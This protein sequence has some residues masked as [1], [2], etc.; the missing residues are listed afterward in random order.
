[1]A[2]RPRVS[3]CIPVYNRPDY[4][5]E[6]VD[7]VLAQTFGD[8]ELIIVDNCSTDDTPAVIERLAAGDNRISFYKNDRNLG[9]C[10]SLN[11]LMLLA[12]GEYI[13][14]LFSDDLLEPR[15]LEVFVEV[16]DS[17]PSVSLVTSFTRCVGAS[18]ETRGE[19]CFPGTG[20]LDGKTCQKDM[21]VNGCWPGS[22]SSVM[23]RRRHLHLGLFHHMWKYWVGDLDFWLRLAGAGNLYV[24]PEVLSCLRIHDGQESSIHGVPFR[25]ITER[26]MLADMVFKF[27][28]IYGRHTAAEQRTIR[29]HLLKRLVREGLGRKGFGPKLKMIGIGLS[30]PSYGRLRF[31]SVLLLNLPRILRGASRWSP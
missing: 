19:S 31:A 24:V 27:P 11:R 6:A 21:M 7:S 4:I 16:L 12:R 2:D 17:R 26:L 15:C 25:L 13:K 29:R 9:I 28:H 23:F 22:P 3:V 5:V 30:N 1:M 10:S 14:F 18:S 8:F 20:Q